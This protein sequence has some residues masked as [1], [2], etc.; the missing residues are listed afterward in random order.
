[1][2]LDP[3]A[4][5]FL[6]IQAFDDLQVPYFI[7]GS[8]ASALYGVARTTADCDIVAA[9]QAEHAHPL[10]QKL[11][12]AFYADEFAIM[13]AILQLS[14]FNLIHLE[15][16]FKVDVFIHKPRPF[17][18]SQFER[19]RLEILE[20]KPERR[21]Y[22]ASAEDTLLAKLEWY[23]LGGEVSERQ[24]RDILGIIKVQA[25]H[26]DRVYLNQWAADLGASDLLERAFAEAE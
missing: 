13:D 7:G 12:E 21:A 19:R 17:E 10:V 9:L 22:F 20:M 26:L 16:M 5:T 24:W 8:L 3:I 1:M 2:I 25:F 18:M 6:V 23:R 4:V 15:S 11:G 14:S